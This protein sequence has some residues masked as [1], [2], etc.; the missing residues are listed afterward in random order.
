MSGTIGKLAEQ[1]LQE[2]KQ[3]G[4]VKLAEYRLVKEAVS[5]PTAQHPFAQALLKL[6]EILRRKTEKISVAELKEFVA[7]HAR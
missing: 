2:V 1:V 3:G 7:K 5:K 6:A 4:L